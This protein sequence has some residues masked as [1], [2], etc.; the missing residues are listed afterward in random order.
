M[1]LLQA[2]EMYN[3]DQKDLRSL[4]L[5]VLILSLK[6]VDRRVMFETLFPGEYADWERA[7]MTF[8]DT[9]T[10]L[11]MLNLMQWKNLPE[12]LCT[13]DLLLEETKSALKAHGLDM[14]GWDIACKV[15]ILQLISGL[16]SVH[17]IE[18]F[19]SRALSKSTRENTVMF[20]ANAYDHKHP[21]E[22]Y[23]KSLTGIIEKVQVDVDS[24]QQTMRIILKQ[25]EEKTLNLRLRSIQ[26]VSLRPR[27]RDK[28]QTSLADKEQADARAG[29]WN[30]FKGFCHLHK[31]PNNMSDRVKKLLYFLASQTSWEWQN[32][33]Q[34]VVQNKDLGDRLVQSPV[35]H[36]DVDNLWCVIKSLSMDGKKPF[37]EMMSFKIRGFASFPIIYVQSMTLTQVLQLYTIAYQP[38]WKELWKAHIGVLSPQI[39]R[40]VETFV[41]DI[42]FNGESVMNIFC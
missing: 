10:W 31:F 9:V 16:Q 6:Y 19:T 11:T 41:A 30:T 39:V 1:R 24:L 13:R 36:P 28:M 2:A 15:L 21:P 14:T 34:K 32:H 23:T 20:L 4:C 8:G 5:K 35:T 42:P 37:A 38:H 12:Q 29:T 27:L 33:V 26:M 25:Q 17:A 3:L 40:D 7:Q 18:L 22:T